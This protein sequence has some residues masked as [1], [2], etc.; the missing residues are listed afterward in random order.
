MAQTQRRMV[1][2]KTFTSQQFGRLSDREKILYIGMIVLGDDDGRLIGEPAYLR[3]QVFVYDDI[4]L[5]DVLLMRN[6]LEKIGLI[7]VYKIG[8]NEYIEHP[9]WLEYQVIRGDLYTPSRFPDRNGKVSKTLLKSS[10]SKDK[11][12]KDKIINNIGEI[13]FEDFWKIYP[14][15]T[16]KKK[17]AELWSKLKTDTQRR[18][19][20]DIPKRML[21]TK[22][23]NGFIKDPERYIKHEQWND[24]IKE[25]GEKKFIDLNKK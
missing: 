8:E 4:S 1:Y 10:L 15:K 16:G 6:N 3:G 14:K 20:E 24:E 13:P 17:T 23:I 22:W 7:V 2:A 18:I 5:N 11:I 19:V 25:E 21:D 12:S 9:N